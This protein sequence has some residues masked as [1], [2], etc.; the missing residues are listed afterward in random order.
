M[1]DIEIGIELPDWLSMAF[2]EHLRGT[3]KDVCS[4]PCKEL[5]IGKQ[6]ASST[7]LGQSHLSHGS[8]PTTH[9]KPTL[10]MMACRLSGLEECA[11]VSPFSRGNGH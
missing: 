3:E 8:R 4:N 5:Y 6:C 9:C 2:L 11:K 10:R 1:L 7:S